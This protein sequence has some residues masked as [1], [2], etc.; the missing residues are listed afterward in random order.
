LR[1]A[2]TAPEDSLGAAETSESIR[3]SVQETSFRDAEEDANVEPA[4]QETVPQLQRQ[5]QEVADHQA[6]Q[7]NLR[8][9]MAASKAE[10]QRHASEA[11]EYEKQLERV[12]EQSMREQRQ[13]SS[14][15]E[16]KSDS[17][18]DGEEDEEFEQAGG[19]SERMAERAAAV[20]GGPSVVQR[21]P[22]YDPGHLAGTTQSEFE[23]QQQ[24]QQ[25][26]KTAQERTEEEI[27]MRYVKKQSLLEVHHSQNKGKGRAT[28]TEDKDDEDLQKAL[29]LSMQGH[30]NSG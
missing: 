29:K 13:R 22:S 21:P 30:G 27:V 12:M 11:L 9:A 8:Q 18:L 1:L 20:A 3:L 5:R 7:E 15:G 16:L 17:G 25:G 24:G 2:N 23:A 6:Q 19:E 14:D 4:I 26:E 28:A 10:A